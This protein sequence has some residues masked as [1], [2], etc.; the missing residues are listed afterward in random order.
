MNLD[1]NQ[2]FFDPTLACDDKLIEAHKIVLA[3][4]ST[5][6][7]NIQLKNKNQNPF[8]YFTG[9]IYQEL[10][11][12]LDL[13]YLG[14]VTIGQEQLNKFLIIAEDL[15]IKDLKINCFNKKQ[16]NLS[17]DFRSK[18][19]LLQEEKDPVTMTNPLPF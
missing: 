17:N 13:I 1:L 9:I 18:N 10:V 7:R 14:E 16:L 15:G 4:N 2:L 19:K 3:A 6:F 5:F 12:I 11:A 8:F